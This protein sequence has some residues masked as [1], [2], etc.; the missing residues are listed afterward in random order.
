M[1]NRGTD[2]AGLSCPNG[3]TLAV[4]TLAINPHG[5]QRA[6]ISGLKGAQHVAVHPQA[7][8]QAPEMLP[9]DLIIAW[10]EVH[11]T[12]VQIMYVWTAEHNSSTF[13][14]AVQLSSTYTHVPKKSHIYS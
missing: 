8:W 12:K 14:Q 4:A 13:A 1:P 5:Q 9:P 2:W 6:T 7:L 11:K 3:W 10:F